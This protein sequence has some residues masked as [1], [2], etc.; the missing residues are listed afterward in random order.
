M[1][2]MRR[3][4]ARAGNQSYC[5]GRLQPLPMAKHRTACAATQRVSQ[6]AS[7][8]KGGDIEARTAAAPHRSLT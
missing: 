4:A 5:A 6:S 7:V 8:T 2:R 1:H 3:A